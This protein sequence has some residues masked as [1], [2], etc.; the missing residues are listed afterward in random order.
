MSFHNGS[1]GAHEDFLNVLAATKISRI[2]N[3]LYIILYHYKY[4][5]EFYKTF[6]QLLFSF[7]KTKEQE[8]KSFEELIFLEND[9]F[10]SSKI[11]VYGVKRKNS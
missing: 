4:I 9:C 6:K 1:N 8:K 10:V 5:I 3:P 7:V 11:C 2:L